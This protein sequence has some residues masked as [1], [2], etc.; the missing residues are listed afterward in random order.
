MSAPTFRQFDFDSVVGTPPSR[1]RK[2]QKKDYLVEGAL[3]VVD[4]GSE[5]IAGFTNDP[6]A[7]YPG[8]LPVVLF[9]DH[10]R[11]FKYVDFPF[12]LGADGVKVLVARPP[13]LP[14]YLFYYFQ[15]QQLPDR[16]Y[17]RHYQF[18]RELKVA[19]PPPSEQN[20]IIEILDQA[21]ALRRLRAEADAKAERILPALFMKM[22]PEG[23]NEVVPLGQL[24]ADMR[25]GT[26]TRCDRDSSRSPVLRIPNII[27]GVIDRSDLKY[28]ELSTRE[29]ER[30]RLQHGDVLF[31]RT[32]GNRDY[33]GRCA[34][35]QENGEDVTLFASYLIRARM[36]QDKVHPWYVTAFLR[37]PAGRQA[38]APHIR[39][40][41]GQSNI[42]TAG[43]R[44]IRVPIV[45]MKTQET[46]AALWS[47]VRRTLENGVLASRAIEK[48]FAALLHQA[49][50]GDLTASWREA[51]MKEL[52]QEMEQQARLLGGSGVEVNA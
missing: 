48:L 32:N 3:P 31:V 33:V 7:Q 47:G 1:L 21:D 19:L 45:E 46:F 29:C 51:H 35:Y 16:G 36:K 10:T 9:G 15:A 5:K 52:L 22:F 6:D 8:S 44:A 25:Y 23:A 20:R 49:F 37:T 4:Q 50:S 13:A 28:A 27:G 11:R 26:S 30:L 18:L 17:S 41:A 42:S 12:A 43:L 34:V 14:K 39:T 38:M 24:V 2:V 40:T